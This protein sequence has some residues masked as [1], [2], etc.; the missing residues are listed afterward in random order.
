MHGSR[1]SLTLIKQ[2][3]DFSVYIA[4]DIAKVSLI[5]NLEGDL[6]N[7]IK[8]E[9]PTLSI[10]ELIWCSSFQTSANTKKMKRFKK[11]E[12][13]EKHWHTLSFKNLTSKIEKFKGVLTF[14]N[15]FWFLVIKEKINTYKRYYCMWCK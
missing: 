14:Y 11:K 13:R 1:E 6:S 10:N 5:L 2:S 12:I 9:Y 8:Y 15:H 7:Q 4:N 3:F